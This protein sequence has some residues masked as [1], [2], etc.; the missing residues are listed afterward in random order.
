VVKLRRLRK[1]GDVDNVDMKYII[2]FEFENHEEVSPK[3]TGKMDKISINVTGY[4]YGTFIRWY[5]LLSKVSCFY[6]NR[7]LFCYIPRARIKTF[8]F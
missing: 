3:V 4:F 2:D 5:S 6:C 1:V 7:K 8:I